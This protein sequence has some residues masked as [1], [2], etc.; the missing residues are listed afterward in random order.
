MLSHQTELRYTRSAAVGQ[1]RDNETIEALCRGRQLQG[2]DPVRPEGSRVLL[3]LQR[4]LSTTG[5]VGGNRIL[6]WLFHRTLGRKE[7]P[8]RWTIEK[9][10]LQ[11]RLQETDRVATGNLGSLHRWT[12]QWPAWRTQNSPGYWC[13]GCG[14]EIQDCGHSNRQYPWPA[15]NK[16]I[17]GSIE[18]PME[19]HHRSSHL[20]WEEISRKGWTTSP[21]SHKP[22]HNSP[23]SGHFAALNTAE[24]VSQDFHWP[25]MDANVQ[26]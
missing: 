9:T 22:F 18:Q 20:W 25:A 1:C 6:L 14:C 10:R 16:R 21:Q 17:R 12:V 11:H 23:E 24:L 3:N 7:E 4:A 8:G 5:Q 15:K 26:K 19:S 2:P 13:V